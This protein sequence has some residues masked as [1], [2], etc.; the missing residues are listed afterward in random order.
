MFI[1]RSWVTTAAAVM[2]AF[3]LALTN[4][5]G[6]S[7]ERIMSTQATAAATIEVAQPSAAEL[8]ANKKLVE[9]V[10]DVLNTGNYDVLTKIVAEDYVQ[11]GAGRPST[12]KGLQATYAAYRAAFPDIKWT[13]EFIGADGDKVFLYSSLTGTQRAPFNGIPATNKA[14]TINTSD[15]Y[16]IKDGM[17]VA[18][19]DVFDQFGLLTQLGVLP[20]QGK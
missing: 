20:R 17:I 10:V 18:H 13:I 9:Q 2:A 6:S 16:Q 1:R 7:K 15:V 12:R 5:Q 8:A 19:W 3:S 11:H 4:V 14:V